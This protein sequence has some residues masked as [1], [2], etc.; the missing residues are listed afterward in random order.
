ME[1]EAVDESL[2]TV[3]PK[4]SRTATFGCTPNAVPPCAL[5]GCCVNTNFD[6]AAAEIV[7]D[8]PPIFDVST[9]SATAIG[10]TPAVTSVTPFV[11]VWTP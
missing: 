6:A 1:S 7:T 2:A 8:A 11:N 3:F 5:A 9:V 10:R 4:G